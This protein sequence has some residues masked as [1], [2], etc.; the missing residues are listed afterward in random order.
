MKFEQRTNL[1]RTLDEFFNQRGS[2][3]CLKV[4]DL[5]N[6]NYFK[7]NV[8]KACKPANF[9]NTEHNLMKFKLTNLANI[10]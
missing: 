10:L 9:R 1:A 4:L 7:I 2:L 6:P 8:K 3:I 5:D